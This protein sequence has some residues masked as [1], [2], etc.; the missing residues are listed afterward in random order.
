MSGSEN[1]D[2]MPDPTPV[3]ATQ[4][5]PAENNNTSAMQLF[6]PDPNAPGESV[7]VII[8]YHSLV[9]VFLNEQPYLILF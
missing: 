4:E 6:A 5:A 8:D 7:S 3:S 9:R 1:K 2:H